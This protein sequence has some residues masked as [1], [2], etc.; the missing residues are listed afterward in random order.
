MCINALVRGGAKAPK[1]GLAL[2][3]EGA[4]AVVPVLAGPMAAGRLAICIKLSKGDDDGTAG[5]SPMVGAAALSSAGDVRVPPRA[6]GVAAPA[7]RGCA[8]VRDVS[9]FDSS[10]SPLRRSTA[11]WRHTAPGPPALA[12]GRPPARRKISDVAT[13]A[14]LADPVVRVL[15]VPLALPASS[16]APL[17][18]S[19][20][21]APDFTLA[22]PSAAAGRPATAALSTP[23]GMAPTRIGP[24]HAD[25]AASLRPSAR[26]A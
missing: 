17:V 22:V 10:R 1:V 3:P 19:V 26:A 15:P 18:P 2:R 7:A 5:V 25:G 23:A 9:V 6:A 8:V 4:D 20:P 24:T 13:G 21:L 12:A 11:F 16:P 14:Q